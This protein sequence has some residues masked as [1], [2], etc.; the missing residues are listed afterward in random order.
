MNGVLIIDKP[1]GITSFD[2]IRRVRRILGTKKV[3]HAGT[4]DPIATGVLV[5]LVGKAC[6]LSDML[7]CE[8]KRYI[9]DFI[10]G[11]RTD[12]YDTDGDVIDKC[13]A[14][15]S[16]GELENV[17]SGFLGEQM[18]IPPMYSAIKKDGIRLYEL[19]RRGE[20]IERPPR[21]ISIHS[22]E[23]IGENKLDI[24]CS[25]GTYIRSLIHDIGEKLGCGAVM[26]GLRRTESGRFSISDAVTLEQLEEKGF[27]ACGLTID[28][29]LDVPCIYVSDINAKKI[30]NGNP[31]REKNLAEG[32][33]KVYEQ[34]MLICYGK[35]EDGLVRPEIMFYEG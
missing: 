7:L 20:E 6:K 30:K 3:G 10:L 18:Q 26:S 23:K 24:C 22:I 4:L 9:A 14:D 16:E 11:I 13:E 33:Y 28:Q 5:V 8:N 29:C 32:F 2:V 15:V 35:C 25:K 19:A 34:D 21:R 27:E 1:W 12:T 31:F 17:I